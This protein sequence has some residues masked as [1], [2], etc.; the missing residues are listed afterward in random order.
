MPG[1]KRISFTVG[2]DIKIVADAF[3]P[4]HGRP[5]MFAHGGGQTRHAWQAC[6]KVLGAN[7]YHALCLDLRGHGESD[8]APDGDYAIDRFAEDILF[9]A[10][11]LHEA[12]VLVG[13]SLGGIAGLIAQGELAKAGRRGFAGLVLVDITPRMNMEGVEKILGFMSSNLETGFA[14]LEE[15]ADAIGQ[16]LPHRPRPKN[17]SGLAKNLRLKDDGRYYWHWDP[18]F[19][20]G[21]QRPQGSRDTERLEHAARRI[22]AP[23]L[24]IRGNKSELG[25][26]EAVRRFAELVPHSEFVDVTDAGHMVAGDS[27]N[28]FNEA[29]VD[30][31]TRMFSPARAAAPT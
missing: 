29:V 15:A 14:S 27:N 9:I 19:I 8:W 11:K 12:P 3:G 22:A 25:D 26:A 10:G 1:K 20:T 31:L 28:V 6:G 21:T 23:T 30:F 7:G 2:N 18:R 17:L 16:Y 24:L 13:A 4:E 5:V